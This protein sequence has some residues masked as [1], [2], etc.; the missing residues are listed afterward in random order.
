[1]ERLTNPYVPI[2]TA[3]S[4]F[5]LK[6]ARK[7]DNYLIAVSGHSNCWCSNFVLKDD[8]RTDEKECAPH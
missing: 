1:M 6:E 4:E 7:Y 3:Q 5:P 2:T 8:N